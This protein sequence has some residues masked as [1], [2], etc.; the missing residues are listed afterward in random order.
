MKKPKLQKGWFQVPARM[1]PLEDDGGMSKLAS[2]F[3]Q[4]A[5]VRMAYTSDSDEPDAWKKME[6]TTTSTG[7][8]KAPFFIGLET[9]KDDRN[10]FFLII[11]D[12]GCDVAFTLLETVEL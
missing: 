9:R 6:E 1:D 11:N 3:F 10:R 2:A 7:T 8:M 12:Y 5:N 4:V